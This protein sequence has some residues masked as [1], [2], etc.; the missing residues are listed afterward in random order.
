M[1]PDLEAYFER[2]GYTGAREPVP[3]VLRALHLA[4]VTHVPFE[5]LDVQL[6]RPIRLDLA[7]LQEKLVHNRR[8]GYCFEQN[9]LFAAVLEKLGFNLTRLAARVRLGSPRIMPRTHMMLLV[10]AGGESWLADVGFGG[11]GLLEPIPLVADRDYQQGMWSYRLK[12]EGELWVL[13][14]PMEKAATIQYAFNLEPQL[15]VDYELGNHYCST[16][17]DSRFVQTLTVQMA[18]QSARHML[19]NNEYLIV[20]PGETRAEVVQNGEQLIR[21]L[22]D[23]FGLRP[24]SGREWDRLFELVRKV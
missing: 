23:S 14:C 4:H 13:E 7:S 19:R 21:I 10:E 12:R 6:G 9:G 17:P 22:E 20:E 11:R 15:P 1:D 5:N 2:I 8:G 18:S 3:E 16:H 24:E